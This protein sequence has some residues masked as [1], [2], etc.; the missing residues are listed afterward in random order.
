MPR[1][2]KEDFRS[3]DTQ[4]RRQKQILQPYALVNGVQIYDDTLA[5]K[6]CFFTD[7]E[8]RIERPHGAYSQLLA[9]LA[10]YQSR[11]AVHYPTD[12]TLVNGDG[13]SSA[14]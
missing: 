11:A 2:R 14:S 9:D 12:V 10:G 5:K 1:Y 8:G 3:T 7:E 4:Y 13:P 6:Y